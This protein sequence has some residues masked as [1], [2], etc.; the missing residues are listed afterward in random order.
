MLLP[1]KRNFAVRFSPG[2]VVYY[3]NYSMS[4]LDMLKVRHALT[5]DFDCA[6]VQQHAAVEYRVGAA[7]PEVNAIVER[8][9]R[10]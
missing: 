4:E 5:Q 10:A 1:V 8:V 2:Q 6:H 9:K 7:V 3:V